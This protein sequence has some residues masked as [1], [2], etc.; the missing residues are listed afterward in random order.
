MKQ[1]MTVDEVAELLGVHPQTIR[2]WTRAGKL[3]AADTPAGYRYTPADIDAWLSRYREQPQH[4][5]ACQG[6]SQS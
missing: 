1:I 4:Q 6:G 2:K 3:T 5:S